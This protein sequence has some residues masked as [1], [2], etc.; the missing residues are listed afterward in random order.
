MKVLSKRQILVVFVHEFRLGHSAAEA[1]GNVVNAS[2]S[3]THR[4][5][6]NFRAGDF[7]LGDWEGR[8]WLSEV[9]NDELEAIRSNEVRHSKRVGTGK[10]LDKEAPHELT[11]HQPSRRLEVCSSLPLCNKRD[12]L[13]ELEC[14]VKWIAYDS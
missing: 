12:P 1:A 13:L 7:I 8:G 10:K 3:T 4:W 5:F 2:A 9:D 14:D 11:E 6:E